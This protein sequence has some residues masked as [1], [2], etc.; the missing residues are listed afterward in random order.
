MAAAADDDPIP[1]E[2]HQL[3]ELAPQRVNDGDA[4]LCQFARSGRLALV[5]G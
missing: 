2:L 4:F 5:F 1:A 3:F